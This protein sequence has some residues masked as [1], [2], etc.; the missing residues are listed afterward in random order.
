MP[1]IEALPLYRLAQWLNH[2]CI[3]SR[4]LAMALARRRA[5]V[6]SELKATACDINLRVLSLINTLRSQNGTGIACLVLLSE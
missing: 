4:R 5:S 2:A 6:S 1:P 3:K